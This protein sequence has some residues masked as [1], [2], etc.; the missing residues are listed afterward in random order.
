MSTGKTPRTRKALEPLEG[1]AGFVAV[2]YGKAGRTADAMLEAGRALLRTRTAD[3]LTIQDVCASAG[4]TSGAFY[5]RFAGKDAFL[6]ALLAMTGRDVHEAMLRLLRELETTDAGFE[7]AVQ[8]LMR[9]M[10]RQMLRHSGVLRAALMQPRAQ[11]V[12]QPFKQRREAFV[13]QVLP[14]LERLHG[15]PSEALRERIR[16]AFQLAVGTLLNAV[17]NDPGPLLLT[18]RKLD[19]ELA[20]AFCAYVLLPPG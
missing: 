14:L 17:L 11:E 8:R 15:R 12:W 10:R 1:H 6:G 4:V 9:E 20:A 5:G 19:T 16:F 18:S 3:A 13:E 7:A 2:R